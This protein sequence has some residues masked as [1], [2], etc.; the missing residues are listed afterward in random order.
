MS[1]KSVSVVSKKKK[2]GVCSNN[3]RCHLY[4]ARREG[5]LGQIL[6]VHCNFIFSVSSLPRSSYI[7]LEKKKSY[8]ERKAEW[9]SSF[10]V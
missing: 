10:S 3:I 7:S 9:K 5:D 8:S 2:I 4:K 6:G 1:I